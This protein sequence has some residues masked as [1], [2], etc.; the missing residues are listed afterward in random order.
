MHSNNDASADIMH[1]E[2]VQIAKNIGIDIEELRMQDHFD[3]A[4]S[5]RNI[6]SLYK[7][8]DLRL[9]RFYEYLE[10]KFNNKDVLIHFGGAG[11]HKKFLERIKLLKIF[12]FADDPDSTNQISKRVANYYDIQAISNPTCI[13]NYLNFG[14]KNVFFWPL[15]AQ[16]YRD[17]NLNFE[18]N[19]LPFTKRNPEL[20]FIGD[21][22]GIPKYRGV[23]KLKK[24]LKLLKVRKELSFLYKKKGFFQEIESKELKVNGYGN[25]W[26]NGFCSTIKAIELYKNYMFGI[27]IHNSSG[28][29]NFR[30]Y[31]LAAFGVCQFCDCKNTLDFVFK[32]G[33]EIIGY[34]SADELVDLY[35]FYFKHKSL[36]EKIANNARKRY[37]KEYTSMNL[38]KKL[39]KYVKNFTGINLIPK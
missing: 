13:P 4:R 12:H 10:K 27:N 14:C 32:D 22:F 28:P 19:I 31:D 23:E 34:S 29:I 5:C 7:K 24:A 35:Y 8:K 9:L 2:R 11:L 38:W 18:S 30:L 25:G 21:R 6:D 15:G 36:A 37:L 1:R 17:D 16:F 26:D 3:V 33:K 39:N 20:L